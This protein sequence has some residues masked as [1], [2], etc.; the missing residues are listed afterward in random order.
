MIEKYIGSLPST[1]NVSKY[2]DVGVKY[3]KGKIEK[4]I[5][6]GIEKQSMVNMRIIGDFDNK[7]NDK[8]L[9]NA[10][11]DAF[12][13]R[14]REVVREE[15]SGTYGAYGYAYSTNY[16]KPI[17]TINIGFGCDPDRSEELAGEVMKIIKDVTTKKL[18]DSYNQKVKEQLLKSLEVHF[19]QSL[20]DK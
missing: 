20:F 7:G 6:K 19:Q 12:N 18:D 13:I 3:A 2:T 9:L 5:K 8:F 10:A 4:V 14:L 16:P 17:Y 15:K 1:N 11:L